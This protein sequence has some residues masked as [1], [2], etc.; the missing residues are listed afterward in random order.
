MISL[1]SGSDGTSYITSS[2]SPSRMARN[3]RAPAFRS[4]AWKGRYLVVGFAAGDIPSLPLNLPLLKG[5]S[6]VGVFWG[7][8]AANEPKESFQNFKELLDLL[9]EEIDFCINQLAK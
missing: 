7:A 2:I 8:F 6:I 4:I 5:A 3:P 1:M 9:I